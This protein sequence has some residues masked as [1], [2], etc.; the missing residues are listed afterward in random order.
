MNNEEIS[1]ESSRILMAEELRIPPD[2]LDL[3][4]VLSSVFR[5]IRE[6]CENDSD[7]VILTIKGKIEE[8]AILS[9]YGQEVINRIFASQ[10]PFERI[11]IEYEDWYISVLDNINEGG[12]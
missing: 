5:A 2:D 7:E 6:T 1:Y 10:Y 12:L 8:E 4:S 3:S 11:A 9:H